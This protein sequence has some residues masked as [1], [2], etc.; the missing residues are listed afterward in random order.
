[1]QTC[2]MSCKAALPYST[3]LEL[4]AC[5]F[6]MTSPRFTFPSLSLGICW[7]LRDLLTLGLATATSRL[8]ARPLECVVRL[9]LPVCTSNK[10]TLSLL[11]VVIIAAGSA[12]S[13]HAK[14]LCVSFPLLTAGSFWTTIC[15]VVQR[16]ISALSSICSNVRSTGLTS[17]AALRLNFSNLGTSTCSKKLSLSKFSS[18]TILLMTCLLSNMLQ[19]SSGKRGMATEISSV[20]M[21][22]SVIPVILSTSP[23]NDW[24]PSRLSVSVLWPCSTGTSRAIPLTTGADSNARGPDLPL[25]TPRTGTTLF[26]I[27]LYSVLASVCT[28]FSVSPEQLAISSRVSLPIFMRFSTRLSFSRF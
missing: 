6:L 18:L 26:C 13:L 24:R 23:L 19:C 1:M 5:S 2:K 10:A 20:V 8:A 11:A 12:L 21:S 16:N 25:S 14:E 17:G 15:S 7:K 9:L 4:P 22:L 28:R 3:L 27:K